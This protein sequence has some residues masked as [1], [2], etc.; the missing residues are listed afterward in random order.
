M[1]FQNALSVISQACSHESRRNVKEVPSR[2]SGISGK[3]NSHNNETLRDACQDW[4]EVKRAIKSTH[5]KN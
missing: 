2:L 3:T 1:D 4:W 5:K